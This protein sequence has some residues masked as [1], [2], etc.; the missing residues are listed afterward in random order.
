[1]RIACF[2]AFLHIYPHENPYRISIAN[3]HRHYLCTAKES[4]LVGY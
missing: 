4:G 3:P 2:M 1:M